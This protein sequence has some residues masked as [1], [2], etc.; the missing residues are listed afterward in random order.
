MKFKH[1][2]SLIT[3]ILVL[4]FIMG[5]VSANE[6]V[7][8]DQSNNELSVES[9]TDS[10]DNVQTDTIKSDS[11][12]NQASSTITVNTTADNQLSSDDKKIENN[13]KVKNSNNNALLGA[14]NDADV[15][16]QTIIFTGDTFAELNQAI[17]GRYY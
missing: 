1:K 3:L 15:L 10:I 11:S 9:S 12:D 13:I 4:V 14:S 2:I 8:L 16:G 7:T 17:T 6:N 5:A